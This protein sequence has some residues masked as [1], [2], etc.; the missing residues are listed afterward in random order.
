VG[1]GGGGKGGG[2]GGGG[3][4]LSCLHGLGGEVYGVGEGKEF[5]IYTTERGGEMMDG[6][7]NR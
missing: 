3:F 6:Q 2:R 5:G 1:G 7:M 4:K